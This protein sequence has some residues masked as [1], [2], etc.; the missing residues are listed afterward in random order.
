MLLNSNFGLGLRPKHY[1]DVLGGGAS[2]SWF[3][4]VTENY[5]GDG[6]RPL[7]ALEKVRE[8]YPIALHG[9]SLSLG[10]TDPLDR[11]YL[12]RLKAAMKRFDPEIVSDHCCWTGV[13]GRNLHDL[14]PLPFTP[15]VARHVADRIQ[16]VQDYLGKRILIE[17]VSSYL[18][19]ACD[20]MYEWEFLTDIVN[21]AGCG[22]LLDLNNVYV[23]SVNHGFEP[24]T[25]LNGL[26][27]KSV[28]QFHL[29]GHSVCRTT[30]GKVYL[31]DTHDHPVCD[32]VWTLYAQAV[33]RFGSVRT[34]LE[35]DAQIPE[36]EVLLDELNKARVIEEKVIGQKAEKFPRL[37]VSSRSSSSLPSHR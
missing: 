36:F 35:W 19:F 27:C 25:Y 1:R 13:Q 21:R 37:S 5:L 14:M 12:K 7:Q 31:I 33:N 29:A 26:P 32:E 23:S 28:G 18:S 24:L 6:G 4:V 8:N 34:L 15:E 3:E 9:V 30:E 17:N 2:V 20:E 11:E 10:S 22:L 16:R